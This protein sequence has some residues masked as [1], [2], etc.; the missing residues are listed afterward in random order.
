M[1]EDYRAVDQ[2]TMTAALG[3]PMLVAVGFLACGDSGMGVAPALGSLHGYEADR[4]APEF[5]E[6][7]T[8]MTA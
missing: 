4:L 1:C 2:S 7:R 8:V 6:Q 3:R 5:P